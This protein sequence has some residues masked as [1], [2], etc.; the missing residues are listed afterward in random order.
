MTEFLQQFQGFDW[1][2]PGW[3]VV[4]VMGIGFISTT[5]LILFGSFGK[6]KR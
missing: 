4:L 6:T 3:D 2:S 1:W 5:I